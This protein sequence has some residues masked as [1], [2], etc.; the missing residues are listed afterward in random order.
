ME[1][2]VTIYA[3]FNSMSGKREFIGT[4]EECTQFMLDY[5]LGY[6]FLYIKDLPEIIP[7]VKFIN[8]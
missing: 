6:S 1:S 3:V 7:S 2:E 5:G 4:V 8:S